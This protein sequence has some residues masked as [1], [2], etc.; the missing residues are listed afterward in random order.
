VT[1]KL[2]ATTACIGLGMP[3]GLIGPTVFMG[4]LGG[5]ALGTIGH[6]LVP[7]LSA[8][9][10][11]YALLG[12]GAMMG[13]TLQAPLA[14]LMAILELTANPNSILPGMVVIVTATLTSRVIFGHE[15]I[16]ITMLRA[17]GLDYRHDPVAV[18]LSRTGV[19]AV[20]S[21]QFR[22]TPKS[23]S[24]AALEGL[25]QGG[26]E[27]LVVAD[28]GRALAVVNKEQVEGLIAG[29]QSDGNGDGDGAFAE[30]LAE[31]GQALVAVRNDA[32]LREA[33]D[34]M[35]RASVDLAVITGSSRRESGS[36]YGILTRAQIH[37]AVRYGG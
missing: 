9:S 36:V 14:A 23:T 17:R 31:Y 3:A 37:A 35:N 15:S 8:S 12:M 22:M 5:A 34:A 2:A 4:A 1:L 11:F 27:W 20:M 7:Q 32:T 24:P 21:R 29:R 13:A 16:Y 6:D 26:S 28:E 30:A 25:L 10:G 19:G 33:L 18:A